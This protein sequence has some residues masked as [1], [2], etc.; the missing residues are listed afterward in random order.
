MTLH[1]PCRACGAPLAKTFTNLGM[2]P[3]SNAYVPADKANSPETYYPLHAL[4]CESCFL[5]QLESY[6]QPTNIFNDDYA[7]FSS[8]SSSWLEHASAYCAAMTQRFHLG[9]DAHIAEA[10]SNDGY[11]LQYFQQDGLKV[12]GIE[13]A[14]NCAAAAQQKGVHTD[15]A[16]FGADSGKRIRETRGAADLIAAN[17]VLAHVPD[18][19][20]FVSGFPALMSPEGVTTFEFPHL[21]RLIEFNQFDT[22]Y[23]EH[24]SYLSLLPLRQV[25]ENAGLR[26]FDVEE[27]PTHG[28]SLRLFV[29]HQHAKHSE[30]PNIADML[31]RERAAG[32]EDLS[33][34]E[35]FGAVAAEI[36]DAV[37][38]FLIAARRDG[39]T[40]AAYGAAAKGNTLINYCGIGP[41]HISY[42]VDLN[43]NKQGRLLPGSR[44]PIRDI[45]TVTR[46]K[47]DYL[48]ILPWNLKD[49]VVGQM[50]EIR[51][52]GGQFVTAIPRLE[53]F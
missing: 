37:M 29:C 21:M 22:I 27:L 20:D 15:V 14:A 24:F 19:D 34:F 7:Y 13:P 17:N 43:P 32:L 41:D 30:S 36:K 50:A 49:E 38:E 11:L 28:G 46:E 45:S 42:V 4:V 31:A 1:A 51:E 48:F 6:E 33:T 47:P 8:Y 5:V 40:V 9:K 26:M 3:F 2:S 44:I 25:F 52:W 16:F 53:I 10:A 12:T 23:H 35:R 39:K 18:L